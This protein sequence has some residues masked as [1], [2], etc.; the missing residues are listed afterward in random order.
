MGTEIRLSS[1]N[2]HNSPFINVQHTPSFT[3][4]AYFRIDTSTSLMVPTKVV[5]SIFV[6]EIGFSLLTEFDACE[7]ISILWELRKSKTYLFVT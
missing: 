3:R 1:G 4:G 6:Q 2:T 5:E 7:A